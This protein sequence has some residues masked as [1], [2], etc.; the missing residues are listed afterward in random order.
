MAALSDYAIAM[1]PS[2]VAEDCLMIFEV[3]WVDEPVISLD[4]I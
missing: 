2:A 1:I 4:E 3:V